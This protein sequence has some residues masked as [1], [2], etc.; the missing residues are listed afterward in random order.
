MKKFLAFLTVFFLSVSM[1]SVCFG[2]PAQP[3][4]RNEEQEMA[5]AQ[6][7]RYTPNKEGTFDPYI[8]KFMK[9]YDL[10]EENFAFSYLNLYTNEEYDFNEDKLF[11][12]AGLERLP[13][14]MLYYQ[15]MSEGKLGWNTEIAGSTVN[16]LVNDALSPENNKEA[17]EKLIDHIGSYS[18]FKEKIAS[19]SESEFTEQF[20]SERVLTCGYMKDVVHK[21]Y[22]DAKNKYGQSFLD[23]IVYPVRDANEGKYLS[24]YVLNYSISGVDGTQDDVSAAAAV[25][26]TEQSYVISVFVKSSSAQEIIGQLNKVVCKYN[27]EVVSGKNG[28]TTTKYTTSLAD[29]PEKDK[30][31]YDG[32]GFRKPALWISLAM[33]VLLVTGVLVFL[34]MKVRENKNLFNK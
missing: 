23:D 33:A 15:M 34:I 9:K 20:V 6:G 16:Y 17:T 3:T 25:V 18:D 13:L 8:E 12:S 27:T 22:F 24:K 10:D 1:L 19:F 32:S 29:V 28:E 21:M 4:S 5:L 31:S 11:P 7:S 14:C 2:A 30:K 26:G